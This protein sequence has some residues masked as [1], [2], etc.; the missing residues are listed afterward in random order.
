MQIKIK[1]FFRIS[2]I[3]KKVFF[4]DVC[5]CLKIQN[6]IN[7]RKEEIIL[8]KRENCRIIQISKILKILQ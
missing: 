3:E 7:I 5:C 1:I 8:K 4:P 2:F 6:L